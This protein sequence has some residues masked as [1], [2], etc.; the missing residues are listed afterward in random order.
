MRSPRTCVSALVVTTLVCTAAST[1]RAQ[2]P[3]ALVSGDPHW[4][5]VRPVLS[6]LPVPHAE[7]R[8]SK[9]ANYNTLLDEYNAKVTEINAVQQD[10]I[11][12][13]NSIS[14]VPRAPIAR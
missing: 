1:A 13:Y 9:A 2:V 7:S 3:D 12:L 11:D 8:V 10:G 14:A 4:V 6:I 5:R